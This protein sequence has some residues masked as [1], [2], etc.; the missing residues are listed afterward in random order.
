MVVMLAFIGVCVGSFAYRYMQGDTKYRAFFVQLSLLVISVTA[1]VSADHLAMLLGAWCL[2][3]ILLVRLMIHKASWKAA[4]ASGTLATKNYL[5]GAAC[6][7]A[8]FGILYST[9]GITSI[10][11][12]V[13][14]RTEP[15]LMLGINTVADWRNHPI[16]NL[17]IS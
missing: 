5:L 11:A 9:T 6:V 16:S 17:A 7:A 10:Q 3:N 15:L 4:R 1:M 2:S 8:A 12:L 13:H 14:Q